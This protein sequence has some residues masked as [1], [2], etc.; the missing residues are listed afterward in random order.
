MRRQV[1]P[2][3]AAYAHNFKKI[4]A[5]ISLPTQEK[6]KNTLE[7]YLIGDTRARGARAHPRARTRGK[8]FSRQILER[9]FDC[10]ILHNAQKGYVKC[11][12]KTCHE[13]LQDLTH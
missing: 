8:K 2:E 12:P 6:L 10:E 1:K 3:I 13:M 4:C 7:T 5:C 9:P 11:L